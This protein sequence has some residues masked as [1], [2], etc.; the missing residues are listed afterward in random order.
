[1]NATF[2]TR[3]RLARIFFAPFAMAALSCVGV[4]VSAQNVTVTV[5]PSSYN[6]TGSQ[7]CS[8][9]QPGPSGNLKVCVDPD[10]YSTPS[11]NPGTP[12]TVSWKL[13]NTVGDT[14][15]IFPQYQGIVIDSKQNKKNSNGNNPWSVTPGST[16]AYS[17]TS[18]KENGSKKYSYT[19]NVVKWISNV[20]YLLTF[21]PTI[22]N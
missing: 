14:G 20:G 19:V 3:D 17:A 7:K 11:G 8:D 22:M 16:T 6:P 18:T 21:D 12:V 5:Q 10:T 2:G 13:D 1:M 15:W 4:S 9:A